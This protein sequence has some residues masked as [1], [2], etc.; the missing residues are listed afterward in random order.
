MQRRIDG[1]FRQVEGAGAAALDG[2]DDGV[3]M[4]RAGFERGEDD[5]IEV[6]FEHFG[7]HT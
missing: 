5:G 1:A 6:P 2:L 4:R 3:A 7:I